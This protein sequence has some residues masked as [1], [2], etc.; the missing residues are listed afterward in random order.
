MI[1]VKDLVQWANE[2][3]IGRSTSYP[4][5]WISADKLMMLVEQI[6]HTDPMPFR[7]SLTNNMPEDK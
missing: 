7:Y 6:K 4:N 1:L 3:A 2:N 5:G